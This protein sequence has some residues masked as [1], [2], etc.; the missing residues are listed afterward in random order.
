MRNYA[1]GNWPESIFSSDLDNDGDMD[2]M[3]A[4]YSSNNI[5]I[6]IN[7]GNGHFA[8]RSIF[9]TDLDSDDDLD[10][11]TANYN[12]HTLSIFLNNGNGIFSNKSDF[13]T[14]ENPYSVFSADINDNGNMD[15]ISQ[16][17]CGLTVSAN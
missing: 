1:T 14:G 13:V 16:R 8:A 4:N 12:S 9:S 11:I 7:D 3:T 15:L 6:L 10:I 5:S 17:E 2:L